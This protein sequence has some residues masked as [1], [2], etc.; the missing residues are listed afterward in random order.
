MKII[1]LTSLALVILVA[2]FSTVKAQNGEEILTKH[3]T[4][5]GGTAKWNS[6]TSAKMVG[7][8][9]MGGME[10]CIT[11]TILTDKAMRMDISAMG[12]NGYTI[13]TPTEGWMYMPFQPG[14]DKVTPIPAEQ[15]K[16]SQDKLNMKG[17]YLVDRSK[18][19]TV[20]YVGKDTMNTVP[21]YKIKVVDNDGNEQVAYIDMATYYLVRSELKVKVQDEDHEVAAS[22]SNFQKLPEGI[23]MPMTVSAEQGDITFKT[24]ELNK[25]IDEKIFKPEAPATTPAAG[26]TEPPKKEISK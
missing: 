16:A 12:M 17:G 26:E 25:P 8:M 11:Q 24:V 15:I 19:K 18:L 3:I 9:N 2:G 7:S 21:C 22:Y 14:M 4:A 10:I 5:V 6:I 13:I 1:K 20:E 23:V